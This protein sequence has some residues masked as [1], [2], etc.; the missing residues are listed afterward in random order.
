MAQLLVI[1]DEPSIRQMACRILIAGGHSVIEAEN[2]TVG[3]A[4][5][6]KHH[7]DL[8]LT[9]IIMPGTEGIETI[10]QIRR[11]LPDMKIIAMSGSHAHEL[12]LQ[13]A[14]KLGADEILTKPFRATE[15]RDTVSRVLSNS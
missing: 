14:E 1:D 15:L 8:V 5:L 13:A 9:D 4:Q 10:Q 11:L 3:L 2:G 12:Y 6:A 7:V